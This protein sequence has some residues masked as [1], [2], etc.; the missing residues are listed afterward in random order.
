VLFAKYSARPLSDALKRVFGETARLGDATTRTVIPAFDADAGKPV[1][2]K[3]RHHEDFTRDHRREVWEIAMATSSAPTYLP[4]FT[5]SWGTRYV[6]GG[7]WAN[8]PTL[9]AVIEAI[10]FLDVRPEAIDVL[11]VGTTGNGF[12]LGRLPRTG[13]GPWILRGNIVHMLMEASDVSAEFQSKLLVPKDQVL[14]IDDQTATP[15]PLDDAR[16]LNELR[17]RGEQAAKQHCTQVAR[18]FL[19]SKATP[20]VPIP[21]ES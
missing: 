16:C 10:R 12:R 3:T 14:V 20:F 5:S 9:V 17:G 6:D 21:S 13:R 2:F 15:I 11:S 8:R 7:I 19:E 4:P 18:R 1:C